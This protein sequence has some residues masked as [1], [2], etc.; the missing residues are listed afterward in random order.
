[1]PVCWANSQ[2]FATEHFSDV[3]LQLIL[4]RSKCAIYLKFPNLDKTFENDS[5]KP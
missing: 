2:Y 5:S 4:N 1:M 3:G